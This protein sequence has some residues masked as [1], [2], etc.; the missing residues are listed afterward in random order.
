MS[1]ALVIFMT[2]FPA[3]IKVAGGVGNCEKD[4][5]W[6][7]DKTEFFTH[8]YIYERCCYNMIMKKKCMCLFLKSPKLK[9]AARNVNN[10]CGRGGLPK[11]AFSEFKC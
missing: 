7:I 10:A 2:S 5:Q 6:C 1:I 8:G 11:D 4:M 9:I 3:P